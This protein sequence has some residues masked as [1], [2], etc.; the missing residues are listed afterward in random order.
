[1]APMDRIIWTKTGK[2]LHSLRR[3]KPQICHKSR[4]WAWMLWSIWFRRVVK[5]FLWSSGSRHAIVHSAPQCTTRHSAPQDTRGFAML[6]ET[7][8][9]CHKIVVYA[10]CQ[11]PFV[12][13]VSGDIQYKGPFSWRSNINFVRK[14]VPWYQIYRNSFHFIAYRQEEGG[15]LMRKKDTKCSK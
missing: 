15:L 10:D 9:G 1:M 8:F 2:D 13:L 11:M 5:S 4:L 14:R 12:F 7:K 6:P 3:S